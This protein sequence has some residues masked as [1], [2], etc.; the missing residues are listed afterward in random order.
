MNAKTCFGFFSMKNNFYQFIYFLDGELVGQII[1]DSGA[2]EDFTSL[3]LYFCPDKDSISMIS[4]PCCYLAV[5]V[6]FTV[7]QSCGVH[8]WGAR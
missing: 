5:S 8:T 3:I 6:L 1:L 2:P 4:T 7:A